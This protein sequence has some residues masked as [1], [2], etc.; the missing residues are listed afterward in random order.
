MI[1]GKIITG[2]VV[3]LEVLVDLF[4]APFEDI[5]LDAALLTFKDVFVVVFWLVEFVV[6]LE[7]VFVVELEVAFVAF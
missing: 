6:E 4:E 2:V 1:L 5:K 7:V 3:E